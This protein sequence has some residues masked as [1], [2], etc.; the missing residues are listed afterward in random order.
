MP[1]DIEAIKAK[2]AKTKAGLKR[3]GTTIKPK[4]GKNR[5]VILPPYNDEGSWHHN[6]GQHYIKDESDTLQAVYICANRTHEEQCPICD[7]M[8]EAQRTVGVSDPAT[9]EVI[10]KAYARQEFL[11]GVLALDT[12]TP[13]V[14]QVL[15][16]GKTAFEQLV[17]L[18]ES[19]TEQ[20]FNPTGPQIVLIERT[21]TGALDTKYTVQATPARHTFKKPVEPINLDEF[22][23]MESEAAEKKALLAMR[24]IARRPALAAPGSKDVPKKT[25]DEFEDV[26]NTFTASKP[27]AA[28]AASTAT[29]SLD[30]DIDALLDELKV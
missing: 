23:K 19:W 29:V 15:N 9:A 24:T 21:G 1:I 11:V 3:A 30:E 18:V 20:V 10:K 4:Q 26:P 5:Y 27:A 22:V 6:F 12:D 14:P 17:T 16:L 28:P 25:D 2:L 8:A 13:D 7:A